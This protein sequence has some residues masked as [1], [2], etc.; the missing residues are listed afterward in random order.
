[1]SP[2]PTT[3]AAGPYDRTRALA[4]GRVTVA[5]ADLRYIT[6]DPEEIFSGWSPTASST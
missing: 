2:L 3:L 1:M 4:D 6:L 5:G